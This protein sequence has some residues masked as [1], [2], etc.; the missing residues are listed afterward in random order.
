MCL[1]CMKA[2]AEYYL[3]EVSRA[4]DN[5]VKTNRK[6]HYKTRAQEKEER[7]FDTLIRSYQ[8]LVSDTLPEMIKL[9]AERQVSLYK[10]GRWRGAL[11][12][13]DGSRTVHIV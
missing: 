4:R 10:G 5:I 3:E 8:R 13:T 2:D 12:L 6:K 9:E 11:Q 7:D 1:E